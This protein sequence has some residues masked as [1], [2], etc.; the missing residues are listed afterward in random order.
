MFLWIDEVPRNNRFRASDPTTYV[1]VIEDSKDMSC[2]VVELKR[3]PR[4][5]RF[6]EVTETGEGSYNHWNAHKATKLYRHELM[7]KAQ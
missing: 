3:K 6:D 1:E 4:A 7:S 2:E 5:A